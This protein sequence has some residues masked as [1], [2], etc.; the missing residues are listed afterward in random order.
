MV[1]VNRNKLPKAELNKLFGQLNS[2]F[3]K[4]TT[5]NADIFLKELLGPEERLTFAKRLAAIVML[6]EGYSMYRVSETL[7]VS[8]STVDRINEKIANGSYDGLLKTLSKNKTNYFAILDVIESI[9]TVGGIMPKRVGLDRY[10][11]FPR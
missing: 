1:R 10:R 2:F 9:L 7:K 11:G 3:G 6:R 8:S 4:L 5:S